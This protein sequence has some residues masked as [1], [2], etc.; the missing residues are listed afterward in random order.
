MKDT[1]RLLLFHLRM[2]PSAMAIDQGSR[3]SDISTF[4]LFLKYLDL[5]KTPLNLILAYDSYINKL[6]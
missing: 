6:T 2:L 5:I 3:I 1:L 4:Y